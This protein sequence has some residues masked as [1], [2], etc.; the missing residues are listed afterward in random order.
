MGNHGKNKTKQKGAKSGD[1]KVKKNKG[2]VDSQ[3]VYD[4]DMVVFISMSRELKEEGNDLFQKRDYEGAMSKYE[5][6][7]CLLPGNHIDV[8]QLRSNMAACYMQ[9]GLSEYPRAVHECNLALEVTPNYGKALLKRARCYEAMDKFDLVL[10]DVRR[11]L[12]MEPN[13]LMATEIAER[14]KATVEQRGIG[15]YLLAAVP[16]YVEP[17]VASCSS[18]ASP[19]GRVRRNKSNKIDVKQEGAQDNKTAKDGFDETHEAKNKTTE[20]GN[21]EAKVKDGALGFEGL[22]PNDKKV[23]EKKAK[24]SDNGL[25]VQKK[26]K[27]Q[28]EGKAKH[29]DE[30]GKAEDKLAVDEIKKDVEK[31]SRSRRMVKLIF[32]EDIRCAQVPTD[33]SIL[34]L[35]E[36]IHDRFPNSKSFLIKYK[37]QEGD[38]VT[39]TTS[40]D[41]SWAEASSVEHSPVRLYVVE[42]S[43]DQ[44]PFFKKYWGEE[45][46]KYNAKQTHR[47]E[48]EDLLRRSKDL[49]K[50]STCI[51]DVIIHF[52]DQF[53]NY[54]GFKCNTYP[55]LQELGMKLYSEAM[56]EMVT[57]ED[58][59]DLFIAAG[60]K[61]QEM[62]ALALLNWGNIHMTRAR[63]R[64]YFTEDKTRAELVSAEVKSVYVWAEKEYLTAGRRYEEALNIKPNFYEG[65]LALGIQKFELAKL[66]WYY[67]SSTNADLESWP[68]TEALQLYNDAEEN[69]ERGMQMWKEDQKRMSELSETQTLLKKMKLECLFREISADEAADQA[70]KM[71]SQI[72]LLWCSMLYERST[73]EFKLGLPVW[74]KSLDFSVEKFELAG[75][76]Q[77]DIAAM[78]KSLC[79]NTTA[80]EG[81]GFSIDDEMHE[82][83]RWKRYVPSFRL[84]PLLRRRI[85]KLNPAP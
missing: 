38:L 47:I 63:K 14:V 18:K 30:E 17:P 72:N 22:N 77:T 11:V 3:G 15:Q 41:L 64:V 40:K 71:M 16:E 84:E 54:A 46:L 27:N 55:D 53:K 65:I 9:M 58:A 50:K 83:R 45:K 4:K 20:G 25:H 43:P 49:Q 44:D 12:Q 7:I 80:P 85:S 48:N 5:K 6:A 52:S 34:E 1:S 60:E 24:I 59:Q 73:M 31:L 51:D 76:S 70:A 57:S 8:S 21:G 82:A 78:I 28:N 62:A 32:G 66:S 33:C 2:S 37:D 56:E 39:I 29:T 23:E 68:S 19:K 79:S 35:R 67:A 61:F 36:I 69:M 75:A 81:T 26:A 74:Q 10:R 42:V 13:N